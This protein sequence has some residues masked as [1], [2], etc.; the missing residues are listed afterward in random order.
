MKKNFSIS[1]IIALVVPLIFSKITYA[2]GN[3]NGTIVNECDA[4][5]VS[6]AA[7]QNAGIF[8]LKSTK[9][10]INSTYGSEYNTTTELFIVDNEKE[11]NNLKKMYFL[12]SGNFN[13]REKLDQ[14]C[15]YKIFTR[16]YFTDSTQGNKQKYCTINKVTGGYKQLDHTVKVTNQKLIFGQGSMKAHYST[17]KAPNSSSWSYNKPSSWKPVAVTSTMAAVVSARY[18]VTLKRFSKPWSFTV[19]NVIYDN[20]I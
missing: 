2:E 15:S 19:E 20:H 5:L 4:I 17:T 13:Y 11:V 8:K 14:T 10:S 16:V 1:L 6:T 7:E 12:R 9:K 18:T 3:S